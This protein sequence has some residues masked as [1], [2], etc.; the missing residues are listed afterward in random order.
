MSDCKRCDELRNALSMARAQNERLTKKLADFEVMKECLAFSERTAERERTESQ[1]QRGRAQDVASELAKMIIEH[2]ITHLDNC[3]EDD[4]CECPH[5][6]RI[7]N[8]LRDHRV[9]Q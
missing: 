9:P 6:E 8:L 5:V 7:N 1:R 3:P 4:T 2:G